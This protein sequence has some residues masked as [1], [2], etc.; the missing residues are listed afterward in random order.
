MQQHLDRLSGRF[1]LRHRDAVADRQR[2]PD[3]SL[4]AGTDRLPQIRHIV[5]LMMENHSFDNYLGTLGRG[6]GLP[7][8]AVTNPAADGRPV[9]VHHFAST[10]QHPSLPWQS[11]RASHLQ[12]DGGRNDGFVRAVEDIDPEADPSVAMGYWDD[13]DL[14]FYVSLARTFPLA[15]RWFASCLGPTFPNRRF[16]MA[17][18]ANGLI[19]DVMAGIIDYP[20]TGTIFDLLNRYG[21]GWINYHHVPAL[22]L[23]R[24]HVRQSRSARRARLVS[25]RFD[26]N[27]NHKLRGDVQT[28]TNLYPRGVFRTVAHLRPIRAFLTEAAAGTLPAVSIV[29]PDYMTCSE[30]NPQ[31]IHHG[32][33]FAAAII[34]A[35]MHGPGWRHTLLIWFYDE[36]GGYFDHVPPP[37]AVGQMTF[38]RTRCWTLAGHVAGSCVT[39][40]S[41][42]RSAATTPP[43]AATTDTAS[44]SR[45]SS[46]ARTRAPTTSPPPST[47]TPR[48]S[49]SSKRSGTCHRSPGATQPQ[50]R[51]GTCSTSA[52]HRRSPSP[53]C[54]P[55]PRGRGLHDRVQR[56]TSPARGDG[57]RERRRYG[58]QAAAQHRRLIGHGSCL[59]C[60]RRRRSRS[61]P[62]WA[63]PGHGLSPL[64][65]GGDRSRVVRCGRHRR[66]PRH[67]GA[68]CRDL[69]RRLGRR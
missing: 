5:L 3:P 11:W 55:R 41:R 27:V 39:P 62:R 2:L 13:R 34:N 22:R 57:G 67:R 14:P 66:V 21:I 53:Q 15:D 54:L 7:V 26:P 63:G 61:T 40:A 16:L 24:G 64:L 18:T 56:L 1:R 38:H 68:V 37:A 49:S 9:A 65:F 42:N 6:D 23:W 33:G 58:V 8:D 45:P 32:E 12:Y 50:L 48:R 30:E 28:T 25:G 4:P 47:T 35:V 17:A 69:D 29:D 20:R 51:L 43:P 60:P 36:H 31:D 52:V 10:K 19:D 59:L 44:V 46:S